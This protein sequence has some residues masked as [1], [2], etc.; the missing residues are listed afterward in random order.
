MAA[1]DP[2]QT[3]ERRQATRQA[4]RRRQIRGLLMLALVV[5]LLSMM[6]RGFH[7]VFAPNWWRLW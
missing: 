5:L 3:T 2:A 7:T 6:R 4:E 1:P